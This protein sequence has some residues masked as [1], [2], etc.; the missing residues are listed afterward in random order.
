MLWS[1]DGKRLG[2]GPKRKALKKFSDD[3]RASIPKEGGKKNVEHRLGRD[4]GG[5]LGKDGV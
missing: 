4:L 5:L 2:R 3:R 1:W